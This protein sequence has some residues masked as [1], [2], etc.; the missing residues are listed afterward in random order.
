MSGRGPMDP[1]DW[2]PDPHADDLVPQS[3]ADDWGVANAGVNLMGRRRLL[4]I[5]GGVAGGF[6]L[7]VLAVVF[8]PLTR[9]AE[10]TVAEPS[11][12]KETS[13]P[14]PSAESSSEDPPEA[15]ANSTAS[16]IGSSDLFSQPQDLEKVIAKVQD[17]TVTVICD[18]GL[19][20]GWVI[21]LSSPDSDASQESLELD[22]QYPFEVITNH[23]VIEGCL[24]QPES[25][26]VL[27]GE[28]EFDAY[29]Y[30]WDEDRDLALIGIAEEVAPLLVS[31]EPQPGWWAMAV[32]SPY[33]LE[34]SVTIGNIVNRDGDQVIST[35]A[36]N[37]GNS[38]G[39]LVNSR[40]EVVGTNS[41]TL[42]GEDYPEDWNIAI[43]F[44][45]IC[46]VLVDCAQADLWD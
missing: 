23:H 43:G 5:I 27:L 1:N 14:T 7:V 30:S 31:S 12:D 35:A 20:S 15:T 24:D 2:M 46:N 19:G 45:V 18:D 42:I 40:G 16:Q 21:E 4:T 26:E 44:P 38:G 9:T 11:V 6:L 34:G 3:S 28:Q 37:V 17:S 13:L 10:N 39:P 33:G 36:L 8:I 41:A 32:G 22:A 29:L 25:V